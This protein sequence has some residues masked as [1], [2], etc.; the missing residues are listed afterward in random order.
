MGVTG[1]PLS[2][3]CFAVPP[4]ERIS[5]PFALRARARSRRPVLS[6]TERMARSMLGIQKQIA[7]T[8]RHG[9]ADVAAG[10]LPDE[11]VEVHEVADRARV[12]DRRDP[13]S[14]RSVVELL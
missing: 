6:E 9:G 13:K 12:A 2:L 8:H 7:A 11:V 3:R 4:V 5:T 1:T 14:S 10:F